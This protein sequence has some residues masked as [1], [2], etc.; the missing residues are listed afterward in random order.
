[1]SVSN[2]VYCGVGLDD[3]VVGSGV[4]GAGSGVWFGHKIGKYMCGRPA[5]KPKRWS[6]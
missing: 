5:P 4:R 1:M 6:C 2:C 3:G